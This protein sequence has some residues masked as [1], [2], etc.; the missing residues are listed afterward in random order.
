MKTFLWRT[1]GCLLLLLLL[2]AGYWAYRGL[3]ASR[4]SNAALAQLAA[5]GL[6]AS[7]RELAPPLILPS[8]NAAETYLEAARLAAAVTDPTRGRIVGE[9]DEAADLLAVDEARNVFEALH[10]ARAFPRCQYPHDYSKGVDLASLDTRQFS[11]M[12]RLLALRALLRAEKNDAGGAIEDLSALFRLSQSL[13]DEPF[14]L[15][16]VVRITLA[17]LG[18][19]TL[20]QVLPICESPIEA[21][22]SVSPDDVR[23]AIASGLKME[24]VFLAEL[25]TS[26]ETLRKSQVELPRALRVPGISRPFVRSDLALL[27][28]IHLRRIEALGKGYPGAIAEFPALENELRSN[29]GALMDVIVVQVTSLAEREGKTASRLELAGLAARAFEHRRAKGHFPGSLEDLGGPPPPVCPLTGKPFAIETRD[30]AVYVTSTGDKR[31]AWKLGSE[32]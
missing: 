17:S 23:G 3:E 16:Q 19:D 21:L 25:L 31:I 5:A 11:K 9:K 29:G 1:L 4:R 7:V 24:A 8:E 6:P 26:D 12:G 20:E 27:L 10:R 2:G 32:K 28:E 13:R 14:L 30:G 18:L 15:S 22:K